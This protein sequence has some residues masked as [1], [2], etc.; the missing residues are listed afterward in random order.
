MKP[1]LSKENAREYFKSKILTEL[2]GSEEKNQIN[3]LH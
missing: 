3:E 2:K 1:E